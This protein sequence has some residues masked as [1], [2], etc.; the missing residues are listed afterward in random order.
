MESE[1]VNPVSAAIFRQMRK[2]LQ[3]QSKYKNVVKCEFHINYISDEFILRVVDERGKSSKMVKKVSEQSDLSELLIGK[4][5]DRIKLLKIDAVD[6][7]ID[8]LTNK[9]IVDIFGVD[10]LNSNT[11]HTFTNLI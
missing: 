10:K 9:Q 3:I 1:K 5:N 8:F 11:K 6:L 2:Q 7:S 4:V